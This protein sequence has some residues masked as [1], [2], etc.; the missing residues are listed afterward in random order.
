LEIREGT[1][2]TD[3]NRHPLY[4]A[5]LALFAEREWAYFTKAKMLSLAI[6][7]VGLVIIYWMCYRMFGQDVALLT[8]L[9]LSVGNEFRRHSWMVMCEALLIV[10]FFAAWYFTIKGFSKERYSADHRSLPLDLQSSGQAA[11]YKSATSKNVICRYWILGGT[12][13]GLAQLTKGSGQLFVIAFLLSLLFLYGPRLLTRKGLWAFIGCYLAVTSVL[14]AYNYREY[15]NPLYNFNSTHV[16]WLDEWED[17]YAASPEELPTLTSYW[18]SHSLWD[19]VTREWEGLKVAGLVLILSVIPAHSWYMRDFLNSSP[20][21]MILLVGAAGLGYLFRERLSL[22]WQKNRERIVLSL[23]LFVLFNVLVT[24]YAQVTPEPRLLLPLVP[25]LYVFVAEGLCG[26]GRRIGTRLA[27]VNEKLVPTAYVIFYT[28]LAVWV[29]SLSGEATEECPSVDP[30][31]L[32]RLRN[33]YRD[34]ILAWLSEE[35]SNGGTVL[36]GP[37][38]SLPTWKYG[39]QFTFLP[40]PNQMTREELTAYMEDHAVG[41][42]LLDG[43]TVSRRQ[44][45][46]QGYFQALGE[47][48]VD[49]LALPDHWE[50]ILAGDEIPCEY[51]IFRVNGLGPDDRWHVDV[52]CPFGQ[53]IRLVGYN[54]QTEEVK[55][56]QVGLTLYWQALQLPAARHDVLLKLINASYKVWGQQSGPLPSRVLPLEWLKP[57]QIVKDRRTVELLSATPPG[58]YYVE[59]HVYSPSAGSWLEPEG[60]CDSLLG[61]VQVSRRE[62]PALEDLDME[63]SI[64]A[65]LGE[66]VR[67]LGYNIE[68]GFRS[69]DNIH[70]TLFWQCLQKMGQDYVVFTH[71]VDEKQSIWGQKDN[72]PVDGFYPTSRWEAGEIVRDQYDILISPQALPGE[73][74]IEVGMYLT[75]TGERLKAV[76]GDEPRPENAV[77]LSSFQV[78]R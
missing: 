71:L 34:G 50:L 26:L 4:P 62:P 5:L 43:E 10:L 59:V 49:I 65:V 56:D 44:T 16:M 8:T 19:I 6:G 35:A 29:L 66:R 41:Y 18:Q 67:L 47:E 77:T 76:R 70:L 27:E 36:Y 33:A 60:E 78:Y 38:H 25:I 28:G 68:S 32:D 3:G 31:E 13:A 15:G 54:L 72:P 12:L 52:G 17:S 39:D 37:S 48:K 30:F 20:G 11:D 75:E 55:Q 9:L 58:P 74:Q 61:P 7:L 40:I 46:F 24:W 64:G 63:H 51:C 73:Y 42:A 57:G 2:L 45:F 69:G 22:Y 1:A 53:E 14:M 21:L 23:V